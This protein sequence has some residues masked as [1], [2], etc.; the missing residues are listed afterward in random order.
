MQSEDEFFTSFSYDKE[1]ERAKWYKEDLDKGDWREVNRSPGKV[2]W[3]KTFPE[4]EVPIKLL[5]SIELPLSA[6]TYMEMLHP[7]NEDKREKWDTIFLDHEI[8]KTYPDDQGFVKFMRIHTPFPL[9]DRSFVLFFPT[10]KEIDW[11]GKR[12]FIQIMKNATHPSKPEG[13][14]GFVRG[15]NGGNFDVIIPDETKPNEACNL[16][17][18]SNNNYNGWLPN[19]HIEW[20]I[21]RSVP[22]SFSRYLDNM[23]EGY[24]KYFK[25]D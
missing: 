8:L 11:F 7:R 15:T 2:F 21:G 25:K 23:V 24:N 3:I 10:V 6:D 4:E 16:F 1:I 17:S 13:A 18:L 9:W 12:A 19:K 5:S 14:D 20:I 22:A